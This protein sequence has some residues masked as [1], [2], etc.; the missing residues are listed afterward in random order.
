MDEL[1]KIGFV[2]NVDNPSYAEYDYILC[3]RKFRTIILQVSQIKR[4]HNHY[5]LILYDSDSES[6]T[7][8]ALTDNINDI[9]RKLNLLKQVYEDQ[10][11]EE[12]G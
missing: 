5:D 2:K 4:D 1:E 8:V 12:Y 9:E 11:E 3:K 10:N 7:F 6:E